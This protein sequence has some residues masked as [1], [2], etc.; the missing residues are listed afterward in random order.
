MGRKIANDS[1]D[2]KFHQ[3]SSTGRSPR[4]LLFGYEPRDIL[5]NKL[6]LLLHDNEDDQVSEYVRVDNLNKVRQQAAEQI[7][8]TRQKA[9]LRLDGQHSTP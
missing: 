3:N 6:V 2:Y 8:A 9:K 5:G 1:M 7:S 4:E